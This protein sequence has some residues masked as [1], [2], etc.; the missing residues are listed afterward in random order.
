MITFK[1][2]GYISHNFSDEEVRN[3]H[4]GV[5]AKVIVYKEYEE[6]LRGIEDFS[7]II[8]ISFLNKVNSYSLI[9]KPRRLLKLG[10]KEENLPEVGVF[11][12]DAPIRPNPIGLSVVKLLSREGNVLLVEN[13]DLFNNTPILD[14]KGFYPSRCPSDYRVPEWVNLEE[15][16]M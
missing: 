4:R 6:G 7:H 13:C 15:K 9:V 3:S 8:L 14:I 11:S 5:R 2:I 1:P 16:L 10:I 12:T